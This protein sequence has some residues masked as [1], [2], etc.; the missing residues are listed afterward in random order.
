MAEHTWEQAVEWLRRQPDQQ[1]LVKDCYYDDPLL[2]AAQRF[3]QSEEWQ[4][5]SKFL[6]PK[7]GCS[8]DLGAGRGI[9]SY[10]LA[11]AG[12]QVTALEPSASALVGTTAIRQ[13]A[14]ESGLNINIVEDYGETLPF[15]SASFDL[16]YGRQVLHH[17]H[18]LPKLCREAWRVLKPGGYF[19]ATREPVISKAEDL[20]LFLDA[21]PLHHLYGGEHALILKEY[22][23]A[24]SASGLRPIKVLGH[25]ESVINYFPWTYE[26]WRA[27]CIGPLSKRLGLS[28]ANMLTSEKH[29]VGP[30]LV[31]R[32]A[33]LISRLNQSPGRL[34]TFVA[35]KPLS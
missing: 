12:W 33:T 7:K 25:L 1:T 32:L 23:S 8:L 16:V 6:P 15:R 26:Q 24:I 9:S 30:W 21:H 19:I 4:A 31:G 18:N 13:L 3:A 29:F 22:T 35:D 27:E 20:Q 5:V 17:A 14:Q 11:R 10:A 28:I 2:E 34:Y